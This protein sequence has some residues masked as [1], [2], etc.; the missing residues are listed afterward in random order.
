ML[1]KPSLEVNFLTQ[2][3]AQQQYIMLQKRLKSTHQIHFTLILRNDRA[4]GVVTF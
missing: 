2:F 4:Q 1:P 3:A